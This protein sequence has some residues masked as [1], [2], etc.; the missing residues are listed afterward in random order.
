MPSYGG[1]LSSQEINDVVAYLS[2]LRGIAQ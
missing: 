2:S 1:K